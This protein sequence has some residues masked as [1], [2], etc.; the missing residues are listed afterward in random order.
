MNP[1]YLNVR[2]NRGML[3]ASATL[4]L[5]AA[6]ALTLALAAPSERRPAAAA[7]SPAA[8]VGS[9]LSSGA[10][11]AI[12]GL[13]ADPLDATRAFAVRDDFYATSSVLALNV[14]AARVCVVEERPI[15]DPQ[16]VLRKALEGLAGRLNDAPDFEPGRL[17]GPNGSVHLD[18]EGVAADPDG[19]FWLVAEGRGE[20]ARGRSRAGNPFVSP[21][22][23]M[24]A[25]AEGAITAA[26]LLPLRLV[27]NQSDAGLEGV[28]RV[29]EQV[30]VAFSGA[31]TA[32]GDPDGHAR[33][34]RYDLVTQSWTFAYYPLAEAGTRLSE[35]SH[36]RGD[37][38]AV[39]ER[40]GRSGAQA[41]VK[42]IGSFS[43]TGSS[44]RPESHAG[45]FGVI[46]R[47]VEV[48]LL[49]GEPLAAC[50]AKK[51]EGL[52]VLADGSVLLVN[53]ND[54][55]RGETHLAR[56]EL[57]RTSAAEPRRPLVREPKFDREP[58][59]LV[60]QR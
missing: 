8:A 18:L 38:L 41:R 5:P 4:V 23:L 37:R 43:L 17:V 54:G 39:L 22:V 1:I 10:W 14:E 59:L 44:F 25:S 50:L 24:R 2:P 34:G 58:I 33:I 20:L 13:A 31:W 3:R 40:D 16:G 29:G 60:G 45:A 36:V 6:F 56:F 9:D 35:L 55:I 53:D 32:S 47:R 15:T 51:P 48:D 26:V 52:A 27:K 21:D 28:A 57:K 46:D 30:Y 7:P 11:N 12:S 49:A 19:G 42:Q